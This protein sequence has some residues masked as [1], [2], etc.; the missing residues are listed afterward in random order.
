M[1]KT[2]KNCLYYHKMSLGFNTKIDKYEEWGECELNA[3]TKVG[4]IIKWRLPS[5]FIYIFNSGTC[6]K[7]KN[8][9]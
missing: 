2:C 1:G 5:R 8:K 7:F 9:E 4:S 6:S 3:K